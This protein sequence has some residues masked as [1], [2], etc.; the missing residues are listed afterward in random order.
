V[1]H[2]SRRRHAALHIVL[3]VGG[4]ALQA[5][6]GDRFRLLGHFLDPAAAAGG[7]ARPVAGAA[8]DA[9]KDVGMPVG[10]VSVGITPRRDQPY[11]FRHRRVGGTRPLAIDDFVKIRRVPD[12]GGLH[13]TGANGCGLIGLAD[14]C[15]T[16][17]LTNSP[18]DLPR[19]ET[20][21]SGYSALLF[22]F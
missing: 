18:N 3:V 14:S 1:A 6:D 7:L 17:T 13:A 19:Y 16:H 2:R 11:I 15:T 10:H 9:R 8:Q 22:S 20:N 4:D 5:A 12:V 21:A